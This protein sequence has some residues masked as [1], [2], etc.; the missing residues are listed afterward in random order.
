[1]P[2]RRLKIYSRNRNCK[3]RSPQ[4]A[5]RFTEEIELGERFSKTL[6]SFAPRTAGGGCPHKNLDERSLREYL[7]FLRWSYQDLTDK[8]LRGLRH[9]HGY[10]VGD[11][12]RLEHLRGIFAGMRAQFRFG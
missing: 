7:R 3:G 11:V 5:L 4:R 2:G 9:Q 10:G 8:R 1:M 6:R 12:V